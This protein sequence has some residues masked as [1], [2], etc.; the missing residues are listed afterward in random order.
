[1]IVCMRFDACHCWMEK[2]YTSIVKPSN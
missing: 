1:L 2:N